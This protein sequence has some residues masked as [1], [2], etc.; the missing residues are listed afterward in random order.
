MG[1]KTKR[2]ARGHSRASR[3]VNPLI[4]LNRCEQIIKTPYNPHHFA[5]SFLEA[6]HTSQATIARLQEGTYN[7]P[8]YRLTLSVGEWRYAYRL[9]FTCAP[10]RWIPMMTSLSMFF[11]P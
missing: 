5:Y 6:Y 1:K 2:A 10:F 9:P 11:M 8:T 4:I 3:H 7:K